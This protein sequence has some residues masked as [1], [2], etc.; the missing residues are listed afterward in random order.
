MYSLLAVY[1]DTCYPHSQVDVIISEWMVS[2]SLTFSFSVFKI[3]QLT[4]VI[5]LKLLQLCDKKTVF[6]LEPLA[7]SNFVS[8]I[9]SIFC[10]LNTF[11]RL[12]QRKNAEWC[13]TAPKLL[14]RAH[15][16]TPT[17]KYPSPTVLVYS[18]LPVSPSHAGSSVPPTVTK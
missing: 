5:G 11:F 8:E 7:Y 17:L 1:S 2:V 9:K 3:C 12:H 13:Y 14:A 4:P 15:A 18:C 10:D 6:Q 16:G